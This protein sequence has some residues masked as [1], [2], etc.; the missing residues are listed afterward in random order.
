MLGYG[1]RYVSSALTKYQESFNP[2]TMQQAPPVGEDEEKKSTKDK[3]DKKRKH[4]DKKKHKKDK[5]E[6]KKDKP[7]D[8]D[9]S[10]EKPKKHKKDQPLDSLQPAANEETVHSKPAVEREDWM[11]APPKDAGWLLGRPSKEEE[12]EEEDDETVLT[13]LIA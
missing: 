3:K 8:E 2:F 5:K 13:S 12:K 10:K 11:K 6:K 1:W 9:K 7:T 4:D